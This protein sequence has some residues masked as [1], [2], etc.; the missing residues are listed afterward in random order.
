MEIGARPQS[1]RRTDL[2]IKLISSKQAAGA[3]E[4]VNVV[5]LVC[6]FQ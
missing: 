6:A 3:V 1:R 2:V 4:L 5:P